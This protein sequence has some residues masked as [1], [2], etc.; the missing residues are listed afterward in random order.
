MYFLIF[1]SLFW[2]WCAYMYKKMMTKKYDTKS[3]VGVIERRVDEDFG[4]YSYYVKFKDL[5]TNEYVIG[6]SN[7]SRTGSKRLNSGDEVSIEYFMGESRYFKGEILVHVIITDSSQNY[8]DNSWKKSV[9]TLNVFGFLSLI[10]FIILF[11]GIF[12]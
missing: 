12:N 3:T 8:P 11:L 2:F 7:L 6:K 1:L 9:I 5:D 10:V 4:N